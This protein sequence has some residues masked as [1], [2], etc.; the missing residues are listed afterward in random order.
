MYTGSMTSRAKGQTVVFGK[1]SRGDY[2]AKNKE[3]PG[4]GNYSNSLDTFSGKRGF[5]M[6][7]KK[8]T[9]FEDGPGP[10]AYNRRD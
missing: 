4:P 2:Y 9:K 7:G 5:T 10:G 3:M 1:S 8:E 6:G